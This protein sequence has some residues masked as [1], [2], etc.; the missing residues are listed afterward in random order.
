M[1]DSG[2]VERGMEDE[3]GEREQL[4]RA[5][6]RG[7]YTAPRELLKPRRLGFAAVPV[8]SGPASAC[9]STYLSTRPLSP[10]Q[11]HLQNIPHHSSQAPRPPLTSVNNIPLSVNALYTLH[12]PALEPYAYWLST[13]GSTTPGR[14]MEAVRPFSYSWK[15][16]WWNAS[17]LRMEYWGVSGAG[18][19]GLRVEE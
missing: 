3:A 5:N 12:T 13:A 2:M 15:S 11:A 18:S 8:D 1:G 10:D 9:T 14:G 17:P 16:R 19:T 7:D 4:V 6:L